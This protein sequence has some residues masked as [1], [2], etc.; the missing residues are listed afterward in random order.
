[1]SRLVVAIVQFV[2]V[3][4]PAT[5]LAQE[6][7]SSV[8]LSGNAWVDAF[9]STEGGVGYPQYSFHL[10]HEDI[11]V[12]G[13]G[14]VEW[15]PHE[16]DFTNHV[17]TFTSPAFPWLSIRTETGGA[18]RSVENSGTGG[19]FQIALQANLTAIAPPLRK[20]MQYL[21]VAQLPE[22]YGIRPPNTLIAGATRRFTLKQLAIS[23]EGYH[24]FLPGS[25]TDYA[26]YWLLL[27]PASA[28]R[29]SLG[30]FAIAHQG[31]RVDPAV[32]A[33]FTPFPP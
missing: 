19:F 18:L 8:S 9:W 10:N 16:P 4:Y 28:K 30:L 27:G 23:A 2:L 15:A 21:L 29:F 5:L 12:T 13:Y 24:R 7:T 32:G 17:N 3:L 31:G 26:E 6:Q 33:R 1:M 11:T 22:L 14:F 20:A 25:R